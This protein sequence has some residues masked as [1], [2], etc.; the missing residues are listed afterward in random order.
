MTGKFVAREKSRAFALRVV[1]LCR[2]LQERDREYVLSRQLLR[3]GTAIGALIREAEQ[4]ESRVD[5][6]HKLSVALK[7]ASET[8]YWLDLL[9]ESGY[10]DSVHGQSMMSDTEELLKILTAIIRTTKRRR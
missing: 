2:L 1:K 3:S 9:T 8:A 5:F 4:A 10:L 6:V 7:E